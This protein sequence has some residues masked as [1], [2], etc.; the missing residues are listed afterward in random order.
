MS[1]RGTRGSRGAVVPMNEDGTCTLCRVVDSLPDSLVL[2]SDGNWITYLHP[3]IPEPNC[4][5]V[6]TRRHVEGVWS[7]EEAE[8]AAMGAA[9]RR[10]ADA[11]R[12]TRATERV[13]LISFGENH[14]HMHALVL[15]RPPG[16]GAAG[17]RGTAL[18][19]SV[20]SCMGEVDLEE[21]ER[22]AAELRPGFV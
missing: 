2:A 12:R 7:I 5:W 16:Q 14:L 22:V 6:Q 11:L 21:A 13:Y 20:L 17:L 1:R 19:D 15:R 3:S 8:A 18:V 10:A 4:L 9:I